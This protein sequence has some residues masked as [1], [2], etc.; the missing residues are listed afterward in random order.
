M[1]LQH[2]REIG[3]EKG[4]SQVSGCSQSSG[5]EVTGFGAGWW[6]EPGQARATGDV[7]WRTLMRWYSLLRVGAEAEWNLLVSWLWVCWEP[8]N[9]LSH[10][11]SRLKRSALSLQPERVNILKIAVLPF[12][13]GRADGSGWAWGSSL[14]LFPALRSPICFSHWGPLR[15]NRY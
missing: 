4:L 7:T 11:N 15:I 8:R 6:N 12:G 13:A 5:Y 1:C 14:F 3:R 10:K 2:V 9:P